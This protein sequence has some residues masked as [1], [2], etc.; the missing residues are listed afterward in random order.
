MVSSEIKNLIGRLGSSPPPVPSFLERQSEVIIYG[1]GNT[2]KEIFEILRS[3]GIPVLCLLDQKSQPGDMWQG[4]P[5]LRLDDER[6]P[7]SARGA[8]CVVV[9]IFNTD[10]DIQLIVEN[11]NRHGYSDVV[12]FFDFHHYFADQLGDRYWLVPRSLYESLESVLTEV[13]AV[14]EDEESRRLFDAVIEFRYTGNYKVLPKPDQRAQYFPPGIPRWRSPARFVDCG[15]FSG[16]TLAELLSQNRPVEAVAAFEPDPKNFSKLASLSK[17]ISTTVSDGIYLWP[18]GVHATSG[19][20]RFAAGK[21]AASHLSPEG[22]EFVQ[23]VSLDD[24][25]PNFRPSLIKMD[26]EG[27]EYDA[28]SGAQQ[29]IAENQPGLAICVYHRPD[30]L[31][32]IPSLVKSWQCGYEFYLRSH[33]YNGFD[34]VM[35]AIKQQR[36]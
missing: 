19:Q 1:A 20:L 12:S 2:G 30:D 28:L 17:K 8:I 35:Y 4:I 24:A 18:C 7:R 13:S 29:L 23:C 31:W 32:R 34:L 21:G 11:L 36:S 3:R 26:I 15:A 14:W 22:E 25:I 9:A 5:V 6:I 33:G 10:T 16:D 27:A